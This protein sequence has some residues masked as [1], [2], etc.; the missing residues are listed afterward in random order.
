VGIGVFV[1][2]S[3]GAGVSVGVEVSA[4]V[5]LG[6]GVKVSAGRKL[7]E[8]EAGVEEG[9]AGVCAPLLELQA[10]VIRIKMMKRKKLIGFIC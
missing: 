3:V 7:V 8:V 1:G 6:M 5:K 2:V 10:D 9:E 4:E